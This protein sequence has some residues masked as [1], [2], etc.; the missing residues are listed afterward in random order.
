MSGL[1]PSTSV[2]SNRFRWVRGR[3]SYP[4]VWLPNILVVNPG[5]PINSVKDLIALAKAKPGYYNYASARIGSSS[6]LA[7]ALFGILT[8][9]NIV[10]V[11][12]KGGDLALVHVLSGQT[13]LY[14][15]TI[16]H[17]KSGKLR[18]VAVTSEKRSQTLPEF[19]TIAKT[20]VAGYRAATWCGLRAPRKHHVSSSRICTAR[21]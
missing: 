2:C 7:C 8:G 16:P 17:V 15:A 18:L 5:I 19:P 12:Y 21:W 20:G 13:Q 10:H 6:H 14:F 11:P 9:T 1:T 4:L 3:T